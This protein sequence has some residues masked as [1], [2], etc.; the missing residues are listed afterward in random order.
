[1]L[2]Q[3]TYFPVLVK[4]RTVIAL[5]AYTFLEQLS[6]RVVPQDCRKGVHAAEK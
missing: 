5:S 3:D 1:M 2:C 6:V 4:E